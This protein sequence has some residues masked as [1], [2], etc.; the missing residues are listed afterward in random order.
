MTVEPERD[1]SRVIARAAERAPR[2]PADYSTQILARSRR[3]KVRIQALLTAAAVVL[4]AGGGSVAVRATLSG[5]PPVAATPTPDA[6]PSL[7][8]PMPAPVAQVWPQAVHTIPMKLP[9]GRKGRPLTLIDDRTLLLETWQSFEKADALYAYD[10]KTDQPRKITDIRTPK[11]VFASN[12]AVGGGRIVWQTIDKMR[13]NFWSAPLS[14][15]QPAAVETDTPIKGRGDGLVVTGDKIA[16]SLHEGGVFTLPLE[17]GAV[18]PVEGADR[19]HILNWPWVGTPGQYTPD[20]EPSFEEILDAET[21][22]VS[23]ALVRPGEEDVRCGV[24]TCTGRRPDGSFFHRL[25]DGS[26][27]QDLPERTLGLAFDRFVTVHLHPRRGQVLLDLTTGRSG[28]LG[29]RPDAKGEVSSI[30]PGIDPYDRL[31]AYELEGRYVI[32]DLARIR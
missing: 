26:S 21:G 7:T 31:V 14:G 1:L 15:G 27:E 32:I 20:N 18:T 13:T 4:V 23:K 25:R 9:N 24:T 19:H 3:R 6:T 8:M 29:L 22:Q 5:E 10:L 28:D 11:G 2:A 12:Y 17:G 30:Q 16:F